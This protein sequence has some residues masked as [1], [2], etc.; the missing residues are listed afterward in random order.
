MLSFLKM[1]SKSLLIFLLY[2]VYADCLN[3]SENQAVLVRPLRS[4]SR[5]VENNFDESSD[6]YDEYIPTI[7]DESESQEPLIKLLAERNNLTMHK[8]DVE[9]TTPTKTTNKKPVEIDTDYA[10]GRLIEIRYLK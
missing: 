1:F 10:N 6:E 2:I 9:T 5:I 7:L 8:A 3:R 4:A